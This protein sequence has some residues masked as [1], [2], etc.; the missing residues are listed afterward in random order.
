MTTPPPNRLYFGDNLPILREQIADESVDL[1]YLDPPF[2]SNASYNVLF[3]E[4]SGE[5]SAA[6]ITAF[7][8]TW[9]WGLESEATYRDV[10]LNGPE[11]LANLLQAM[12]GFLG[13]NDMMAYLA[14]MAPRM[15]ELR[16]ILKPTGSIYLHCD[17]TAGRYLSILMDSIF[18]PRNFR[19]QIIWKRTSAH[20]NA[21]RFGRNHDMILFYSKS[22]RYAWNPAYQAYDQDYIDE[23]YRYEDERGRYRRSDLTAPGVRQGDSGQPW[24][25]VNPTERRRHWAVPRNVIAEIAPDD[26]DDLTS[27]QKL[28]LLDEAGWIYWPPRGSVPQVKHYLNPDVP[29]MPAQSTWTD[30]PPI[31]AQSAERLGYPTQKP[32][33][34]LDRIIRASSN[35][36]DLVLDPFCGCGTATAVAERLNRR[37]IGIDITHLAVS[38]MRYRLHNSFGDNLR[39]YDVIGDP[40]DLASAQALAN[41]SEHDGRYQFQYWALSLVNAIPAQDQ[42]RG[43][44]RGVDG[45]INFFDDNSGRAKRI[46]AQVKSGNVSVTDIRDL[47]GTLERERAEIALFITL[48]PPTRPMLQEAAVAGFYEPEHFPDHQFPRLQMLTIAELFEGRQADYPRFAPPPSY[49]RGTGRPRRR[50][51][52][53]PQSAL[54]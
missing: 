4:Q 16:R 43:A 31:S 41:E 45:Y 53:T 47:R 19:N 48:N 21:R 14:M 50:L 44:D 8:D 22:N 28:D 2:N 15:A 3:R 34:L 23:F 49:G 36:G 51:R 18:D 17:D 37:W 13:Q 25:G 32:E 12:R 38:L 35:E 29:G 6:Q 33:A 20:S 26:G 46:V 1:I 40:K 54:I 52:E 24:R 11:N 42:R 30:I 27:Q 39:P 10:T 9:H 7:E 5:E